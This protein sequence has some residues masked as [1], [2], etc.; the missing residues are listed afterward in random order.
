[1]KRLAPNLLSNGTYIVC[2]LNEGERQNQSDAIHP[3]VY[4]ELHTTKNY[5]SMQL[6]NFIF[7]IICEISQNYIF[8]LDLN[9]L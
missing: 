9:F 4:T 7:C 2:M 6:F 5:K 3:A 1:M 8:T